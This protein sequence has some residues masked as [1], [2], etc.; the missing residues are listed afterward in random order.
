V[1][2][3]VEVY[4]VEHCAE[5]EE[6]AEAEKDARMGDPR[7]EVVEHFFLNEEVLDEEACAAGDLVGAFEG[8]WLADAPEFD[9]LPESVDEQDYGD[10]GD[11]EGGDFDEMPPVLDVPEGNAVSGIE[12]N[13]HLTLL[14]FIDELN[15]DDSIAPVTSARITRGELFYLNSPQKQCEKPIE[16]AVGGGIH[17]IENLFGGQLYFGIRLVIIPELKTARGVY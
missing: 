8:V 3:D 10:D 17:Q 13:G 6:D 16:S 12:Q 15:R 7:P 11:G 5:K 2:A 14:G 4:G 1:F 9:A